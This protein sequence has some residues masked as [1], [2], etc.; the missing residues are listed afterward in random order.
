MVAK[1][2]RHETTHMLNRRRAK[3]YEKKKLPRNACRLSSFSTNL[4][5]KS[6]ICM[7]ILLDRKKKHKERERKIYVAI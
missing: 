3:V 1:Y 2:R 7:L 6:N 5:S 4:P